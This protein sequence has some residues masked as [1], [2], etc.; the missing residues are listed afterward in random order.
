MCYGDEDDEKK[1]FFNFK[2]KKFNFS[3]FFITLSTGDIRNA[4]IFS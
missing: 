1:Y 2:N 4:K 3:F